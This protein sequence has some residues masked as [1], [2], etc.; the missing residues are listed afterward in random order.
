[1]DPSFTFYLVLAFSALTAGIAKSG[2]PGMAMLGTV[3]VPTVMSARLSTGYVLPFLLFADLIAITYWRK[4]AVMRHLFVLLPPMFVGILAGFLLMDRIPE[5][6]YGKVLGG[7][8]IL[9]LML[10]AMCRYLKIRIPAD[11]RL[12]AW[13]TGLLAGIMTM[14]ANAAGP[15][16]MLYLLAMN[17]SKEQFV[18]TS[19]WLYLVINL[20]KTPFSIA[21]GLITPDSFLINLMLL[22]CVIL[23]SALGIYLVRRLS[24]PLFEKLMLGMV[25]VGGLQ[26]FFL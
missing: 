24:G 13:G 16:I 23:G 15:I 6:I 25:L 17:I 18:G 19:A 8:I 5:T 26:L 1:M 3:F 14:L 7:I 4:A 20:V 12:F 2:V 22:P 11:S 10:D 9:L 21:L